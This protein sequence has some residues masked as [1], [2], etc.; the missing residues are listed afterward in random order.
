MV[1]LARRSPLQRTPFADMTSTLVSLF[2]YKAWAGRELLAALEA[3]DAT[4]HADALR[5]MLDILGHAS[6]V[7][8]IFRNHLSGHVRETFASSDPASPLGLGDLRELVLETDAWYVAFVA[9]A[10]AAQLAQ[11][12]PFTFTDGERGTMTREEMLLHVA[13]HAGYHRGSIGQL[14]ENL[15]L[16]SPPDSLTKFLHRHEPARRVHAGQG[17]QP[18]SGKAFNRSGD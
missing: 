8:R 18:V 15:G 2:Q 9:R 7:D 17:P 1:A 3:V 11:P 5:Q 13:T 16:P 14:L 12:I 4:R 6:V 10:D